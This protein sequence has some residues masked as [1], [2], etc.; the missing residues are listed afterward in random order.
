MSEKT[1]QLLCLYPLSSFSVL[2]KIIF[3][4]SYPFQTG[5]CELTLKEILVEQEVDDVTQ[6]FELQPLDEV[7][8]EHQVVVD[9]EDVE[10]LVVD[11][12]DDQEGAL[13]LWKFRYTGMKLWML[14]PHLKKNQ[15]MLLISHAK[16]ITPRPV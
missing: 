11:H 15:L 9:V 3:I 1:V 8:E 10:D 12:V 4:A 13:K 16:L 14:C 5:L 6:I 7:V 2:S